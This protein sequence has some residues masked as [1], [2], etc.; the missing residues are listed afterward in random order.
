VDQGVGAMVDMEVKEIKLE[1]GCI[2]ASTP[3][4]VHST[5]VLLGTCHLGSI[6]G[7]KPK[8]WG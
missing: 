8:L 4:V 7:L 5:K 6:F 3:G 1:L 2:G